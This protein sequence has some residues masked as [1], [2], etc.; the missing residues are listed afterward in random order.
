[1]SGELKPKMAFEVGQVLDG[2][3]RHDRVG[4]RGQGPTK[5]PEDWKHEEIRV[6]K[7]ARKYVYF[8]IGKWGVEYRQLIDSPNRSIDGYDVEFPELEAYEARVA[9]AND[10]MEEFGFGTGHYRW[11]SLHDADL[12]AVADLLKARHGLG[13]AA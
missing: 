8:A 7:I 11:N 3:W 13:D 4:F 12:F 9:E 10:A 2:V 1:M 6:T 5:P